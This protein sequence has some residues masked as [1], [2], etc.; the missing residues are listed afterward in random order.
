M[1]NS[2][3]SAPSSF[4]LL[5]AFFA[6]L[7]TL[8]FIL[9]AHTAY[10]N[11]QF[12]GEVVRVIG[13][14]NHRYTTTSH[15]RHGTTTT[16]HVAFQFHDPTGQAYA[17]QVTAT[18]GTYYRLTA[19]GAVPV[20]YL[21][22]FPTINRID[23]PAEDTNARK[24]AWIFLAVGALFGGG[25][26]FSFIEMER[27]IFYRRWLR[28]FGT[29]CAGKVEEID[30]STINVNHENLLYLVYSYTDSTGKKHRDSTQCVS[31]KKLESWREHQSISVFYDP[32]DF[33]KSTVVL[34]HP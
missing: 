11:W 28:R 25:G 10:R 32:R 24:T 17:T 18:S 9:G 1:L 31:P 14:V 5:A 2:F 6:A 30:T 13:T 20:K 3:K 33:S 21:P 22:H 8:F 12:S 15:S 19:P 16:Y 29:R 4:A 34:D 23:L 7:G 27:L 26:W